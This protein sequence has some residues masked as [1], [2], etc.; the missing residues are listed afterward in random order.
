MTVVTYE[1]R[2]NKEMMWAFQVYCWDAVLKKQCT[3]HKSDYDYP[4]NDV[5]Q[6]AALEWAR[7]LG[8]SIRKG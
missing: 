1:T 4:S 3:I 8:I 2:C 5:A 7:I 6:R